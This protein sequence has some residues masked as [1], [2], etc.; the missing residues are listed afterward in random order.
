VLSNKYRVER[1]LGAGGMSVVVA[2]TRF[3]LAR[4][5]ALRF[6]SPRVLERPDVASRVCAAPSPSAPAPPVA[7]S[8]G[9]VT[10]LEPL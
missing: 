2:T 5:V 3:A 4:L 1:I 7:P 10:G 6:L 8:R 9:P